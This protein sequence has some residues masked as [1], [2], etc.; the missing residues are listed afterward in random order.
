M[1]VCVTFCTGSTVYVGEH[2][3]R[4]ESTIHLKAESKT[5]K[6]Q[7]SVPPPKPQRLFLKRKDEHS[8]DITENEVSDIIQVRITIVFPTEV[9]FMGR[10]SDLIYFVVA[11]LQIF[12]FNTVGGYHKFLYESTVNLKLPIIYLCL[13]RIA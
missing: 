6:E 8:D 10:Y 2:Y 11:Y 5:E 4:F 9:S 7:I 13:S 12:S 3:L 1:A